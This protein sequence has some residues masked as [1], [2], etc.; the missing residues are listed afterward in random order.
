MLN[1][2]ESKLD[3]RHENLWKVVSHRNHLLENVRRVQG[4]VD[5]WYHSIGWL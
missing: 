4:Q 5:E 2:D 1:R 3:D